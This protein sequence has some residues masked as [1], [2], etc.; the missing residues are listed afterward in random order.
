MRLL[1]E[2]NADFVYREYTDDP[3]T[4]DEIRNALRLL[5]V[6]P[7]DVLRKNDKAYKALSWTGDEADEAIIERMAAHP[8]LLQRP[9]VLNNGKA[10]LGRPASNVLNVLD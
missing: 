1:K 5:G 10:A 7:R 3:L 6:R 4:T 9:I 2:A 8:T